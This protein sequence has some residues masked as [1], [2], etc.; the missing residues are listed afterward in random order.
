M[1]ELLVGLLFTA[2]VVQLG[3]QG[4][5]VG[6]A[7]LV[8]VQLKVQLAVGV[9]VNAAPRFAG[10]RA[11]EDGIVL[12]AEPA[13]VFARLLAA[14][15]EHR[16]R[17]ADGP[18]GADGRVVEIGHHRCQRRPVLVALGLGPH[19][20]VAGHIH[21]HGRA[22]AAMLVMHRAHNGELVRVLG[23]HRE[24]FAEMNAGRGGLD[25]LEFPADFRGRFRLG[26]ERFVMA[27]ATPR[28]DDDARLGFALRCGRTGSGLEIR[29]QRQPS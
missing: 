13:T 4:A 7:A 18:R 3:E 21:V 27:H 1:I 22:V 23:Q 6:D 12:G 8:E 10:R 29:G 2:R 5:A 20:V 11:Y 25:V 9:A 26:V 24:V 19:G 17:H 14:V 16:V 15:V 28:V